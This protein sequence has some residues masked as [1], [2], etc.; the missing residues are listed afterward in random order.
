MV[1]FAI[2]MI[3]WLSA[4]WCY[5]LSIHDKL[6]CAKQVSHGDEPR[7]KIPTK[8]TNTKKEEKVKKKG[9]VGRKKRQGKNAKKKNTKLNEKRQEKWIITAIRIFSI[10]QYEN[11]SWQ[12]EPSA[13]SAE[14][15]SCKIISLRYSHAS[16]FA[17]A[18]EQKPYLRIAARPVQ[19]TRKLHL[20]CIT[21]ITSIILPI[22]N[23]L[24]LC[25]LIA[26]CYAFLACFVHIFCFTL[27]L[28][29]HFRLWL[30]CNKMTMMLSVIVAHEYAAI[31][32]L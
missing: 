16:D 11:R 24:S 15:S 12:W 3:E 19:R 9:K 18:L 29:T 13:P 7:G 17:Q 26:F 14:Y 22:G 6:K 20:T 27:S 31:L 5:C 28:Y 32:L 1:A 25:G 8:K 10:C 21:I 4:T 30:Q 23:Y 2:R